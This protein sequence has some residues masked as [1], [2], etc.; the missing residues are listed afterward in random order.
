M[1][2]VLALLQKLLAVASIG[3]LGL[4]LLSSLFVVFMVFASSATSSLFVLQDLCVQISQ[5]LFFITN[6]EFS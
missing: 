1:A 2:V 5:V 3:L 4:M 6:I